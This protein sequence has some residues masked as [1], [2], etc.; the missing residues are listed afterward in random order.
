MKW[1]SYVYTYI[2]SLWDFPLTSP[3]HP[4]PLGHR[5]APSWTPCAIQQLPTGYLFNAHK[6]IYA[7]PNLSQCISPTPFPC[8]STSLFFYSCPANRF[9]C[10]IFLD[11]TCMHCYSV[12]KSCPTL[13]DPLDC[14][15]A[16]FP[17]LHYLLEF[18]QTHAPW[19]GDSI[20]LSHPLLSPSPIAL[21]LFHHQNLFQWVSSLH[22]VAKLLRTYGEQCQTC[23]LWRRFSFGTTDQTWSLR[24]FVWKRLYHRDK[25]ERK[26]LT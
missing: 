14:S 8:V 16:V 25:G 12:S 6:C 18:S 10:T 24:A 3:L 22:R 11:S 1:I 19:V 13:C 26:L 21:N 23:D 4:S 5:W 2:S 20:Q 7:S 9:I 15:S 17:V